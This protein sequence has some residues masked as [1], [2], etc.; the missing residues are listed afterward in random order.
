MKKQFF[1]FILVFVIAGM[2]TGCTSIKNKFGS[3]GVSNEYLAT[4]TPWDSAIADGQI[5]SGAGSVGSVIITS[6][7]D[8]KFNLYDATSTTAANR[9]SN[10]R[11]TSSA[12]IGQ[13]SA[14]TAGTYQVDAVFYDGLMIDVRSGNT[15]TTTIT[16][17]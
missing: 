2:V 9:P 4:S 6:V 8:L 3:V 12:L 1:I 7:G 15:G 17:R 5:K 16:F 14:A 10:R 13:F 11:A